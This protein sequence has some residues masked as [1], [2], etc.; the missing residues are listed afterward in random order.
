MMA[1]FC[2]LLVWR[3]VLRPCGRL[4]VQW[5]AFDS[6]VGRAPDCTATQQ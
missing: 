5:R 1:A 2:R 6:S 3:H 4:L